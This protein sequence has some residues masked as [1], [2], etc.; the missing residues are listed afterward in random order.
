MHNANGIGLAANQIGLDKRIFII[1]V[2]PV[3]GYEKFK[4]M[5]LI[6]PKIVCTSDELEPFEEGC[7]SIPQLKSDVIRPK[8]IEISFFDV[9]MK[10][11][12]IEVSDLV[13]RVMQHELDHLNGIL[14]IDHLSEES[15]IMFKKHLNRIKNRK[16]DVDYPI[17][18]TAKYKLKT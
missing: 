2:S 11:N 17:S 14:F 10:E 13:A 12:K 6:N 3:E 16:L 4:P 7:L 15:K 1:D 18:T 8:S 9:D 5:T